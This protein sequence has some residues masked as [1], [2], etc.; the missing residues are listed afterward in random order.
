MTANPSGENLSVVSAASSLPAGPLS[1]LASAT[2]GAKCAHSPVALGRC[3]SASASRLSTAASGFT[4]GSTPPRPASGTSRGIS[5]SSRTSRHM[6]GKLVALVLCVSACHSIGAA[7]QADSRP[8]CPIAAEVLGRI[9]GALLG[10]LEEPAIV[11]LL[12]DLNAEHPGLGEEIR[13]RLGAA[14]DEPGELLWVA[15]SWMSRGI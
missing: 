8:G 12:E 2:E 14:A 11:G 6:N 13:G 7:E 4:S 15:P 3:R 10:D 5:I 1:G 9:Q